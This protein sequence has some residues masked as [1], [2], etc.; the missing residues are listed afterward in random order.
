[1]VS[2]AVSVAPS[3]SSNEDTSDATN[4]ETTSE[5]D[6][7]TET[8]NKDTQESEDN[9]DSEDTTDT[10]S[11]TTQETDQ[12]STEDNESDEEKQITTTNESGDGTQ[13]I[14]IDSYLDTNYIIDG[15]HYETDSW[16]NEETG[17]T[18]YIVK[19]LPDT[20]EYG[21]EI[22]TAFQDGAD[23][24]RISTMINIAENILND[25]PEI[26]NTVH[27][28]SVNWVTYNGDYHI[29]LIQDRDQN[30]IN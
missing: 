19:I 15:T 21:E 11:E 6:D 3:D 27:I 29:T 8:E 1:M 12:D 20:E 26:D 4:E 17:R 5:T 16:K 14:N 22:T 18:E 30:T 28:E 2:L 7:N 9:T 13:K 25:L 24:E 10:A 23:D